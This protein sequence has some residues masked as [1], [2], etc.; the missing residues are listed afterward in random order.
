M[1]P[2]TGSQSLL[3]CDR[4]GGRFGLGSG[5]VVFVFVYLSLVV[6]VI[7]V[8]KNSTLP[9][10]CRYGGVGPIVELVYTVTVVGTSCYRS[11]N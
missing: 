9:V 5:S 8:F 2:E 10:Q 1:E 6:M 4:E 3:G 11:L 7:Y